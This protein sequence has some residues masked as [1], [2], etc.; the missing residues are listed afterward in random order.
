M[1][2]L[3]GW[4]YDE[5]PNRSFG[6]TWGWMAN[7]H[8]RSNALAGDWAAVGAVPP[9]GCQVSTDSPLALPKGRSAEMAA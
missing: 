1:Q 3:L 5:I 7:P 6:K 2:R 4:Y 9:P 8:R